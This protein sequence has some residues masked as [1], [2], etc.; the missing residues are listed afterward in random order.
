MTSNRAD[1]TTLSGSI[2]TRSFPELLSLPLVPTVPEH[3]QYSL[4]S[5]EK[6]QPNISLPP[7]VPWPQLHPW[8]VCAPR[9]EGYRS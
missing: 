2:H 4:M 3:T 6:A 5:L 8:S 7:L 1:R 9:D